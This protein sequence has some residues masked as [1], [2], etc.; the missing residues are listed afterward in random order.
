M[1]SLDSES[2]RYRRL[3]A[4]VP[5][6]VHA[7]AAEGEVQTRTV[8][9]STGGGAFDVPAGHSDCAVGDCVRVVLDLGAGAPRFSTV[10][11]VRHLTVLAPARGAP[12]TM[13]MGVQF[14]EALLL[15]RVP[16]ADHAG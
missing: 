11:T 8:D 9:V 5:A 3:S 10:G 1:Q 16:D 6:W 7:D 13:R 2:R 15:S 14:R 12:V 4:R